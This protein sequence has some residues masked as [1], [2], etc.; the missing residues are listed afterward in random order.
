MI[1]YC[2]LLRLSIKFKVLLIE[3]M[4]EI[5]DVFADRLFGIWHCRR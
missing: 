1:H 2:D 4:D 3:N 5:S